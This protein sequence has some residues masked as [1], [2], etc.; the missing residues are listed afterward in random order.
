MR[1]ILLASVLLV[2]CSVRYGEYRGA[3][4]CVNV[5]GPGFSWQCPETLQAPALPDSQRPPASTQ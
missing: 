1:W 4:G 5:T 3:V 2:G